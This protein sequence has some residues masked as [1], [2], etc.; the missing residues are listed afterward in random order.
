MKVSTK[1]QAMDIPCPTGR[2]S[3][4]NIS[5]GTSHVSGPHDHPNA[6]EMLHMRTSTPIAEPFENV[7]VPAVPSSDAN[8]HA[9]ATFIQPSIHIYIMLIFNF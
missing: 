5:V 8:I 6:A 1:L 4:G 2:T 9:N 3:I 7:L